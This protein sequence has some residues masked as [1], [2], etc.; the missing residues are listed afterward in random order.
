M[1][2]NYSYIAILNGSDGHTLWSLNSSFTG[3]MS[4]VSLISDQHGYDGALFIS[5]GTAPTR[6]SES[7]VASLEAVLKTG[8]FD[9][10]A[11]K[12][13]TK[14]ENGDTGASELENNRMGSQVTEEQNGT[15]PARSAGISSRLTASKRVLLPYE[16]VG[17]SSAPSDGHAAVSREHSTCTHGYLEG[18]GSQDCRW[19][20]WFSV[21]GEAYIREKRHGTEDEDEDGEEGQEESGQQED[22]HDQGRGR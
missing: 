9:E 14:P 6:L 2:Y 19:Y 17:D 12:E 4:G 3:M 16:S 20:E 8:L 15:R 22:G 11:Q 10:E 5:V 7:Q 13:T 18:P 21:G 1:W